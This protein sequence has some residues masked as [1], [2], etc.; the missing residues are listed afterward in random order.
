MATAH[1]LLH[2]RVSA[3]CNHAGRGGS[4]KPCNSIGAAGYGRRQHAQRSTDALGE[5][6]EGRRLFAAQVRANARRLEHSS[7]R[8]AVV[9]ARNPPETTS[10][11]RMVHLPL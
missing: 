9:R 3:G 5:W 6:I 4:G 2:L 11:L 1:L 7:M 10:W 8:L